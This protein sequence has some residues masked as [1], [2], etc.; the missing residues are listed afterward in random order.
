MEEKK[1][2]I[3]KINPFIRKWEKMANELARGYCP[4]IKPCRECGYPIVNGY[5]CETC[6]SNNP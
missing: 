4:E 2:K 5:C 3:R 6:G 1:R